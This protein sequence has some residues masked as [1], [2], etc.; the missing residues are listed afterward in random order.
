MISA[1]S[2]LCPSP[3][4][5]T[6]PAAIAMTFFIAAADLD[7]DDIVAA[8]QAEVRSAKLRLHELGRRGVERRREHRRRQLPRDFAREARARQHDH[9]MAAARAPAAITSDMRSSVLG[10]EALGRA[11]DRSRAAASS[12]A[13]ARI[14]ARQP[15][16][17]TADT[18]SSAPRERVV[19]RV[20][21]PTTLAGSVT[22]GR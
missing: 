9:R 21:S 11:D 16:D 22:S 7:A 14:T 6:T 13:A 15:C 2:A 10:L 19:E 18:T 8:V 20:R 17:G 1:A 5:S 12:G 4:P 3:S